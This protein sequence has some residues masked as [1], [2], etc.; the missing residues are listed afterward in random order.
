MDRSQLKTDFSHY[1][2]IGLD[3]LRA[4]SI[5]LVLFSHGG[6]FFLRT[7]HS[8]LS[9]IVYM[10]ITGVEIFFILSGYLIGTILIKNFK[11]GCT[12]KKAKIFLIRRWFRTI[13]NYLLFLLINLLVFY[14]THDS[15]FTTSRMTSLFFHHLTFTQNF[16]SYEITTFFPE[17]WSLSIEEWFYVLI[18][19]TIGLYVKVFQ[20]TPQKAIQYACLSLLIIPFLLRLY[21]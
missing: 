1:R 18:I 8:L 3:L 21:D 10:G 7:S 13:P 4:I 19:F 5:I 17:S 2:I 9:P 15:D 20:R 16:S 11:D 6:G 12:L 14:F